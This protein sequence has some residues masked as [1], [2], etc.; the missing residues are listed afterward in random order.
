[1]TRVAFRPAVSYALSNLTGLA[2]GI[3]LSGW[4]YYMVYRAYGSPVFPLYNAVFKSIYFEPTNFRD[5]RYG[6]HSVGQAIDFIGT[7]A[8]GTS[9][10]SEIQFA[11]A[12]MLICV[13]LATSV[14]AGLRGASKPAVVGGSHA[15]TVLLWFVSIG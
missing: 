6:F 7:A 12:R 14:L 1:V 10:T 13:L 4:W 9:K 11:D 15:P 8:T 3:A 2:A 5:E